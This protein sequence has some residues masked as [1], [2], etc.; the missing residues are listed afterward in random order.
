MYQIERASVSHIPWIVAVPKF[1]H[2]FASSSQIRDER[3]WKRLE[4]RRS[5]HQSGHSWVEGMYWVS[6]KADF[7]SR[8]S[9]ELHHWATRS[10]SEWPT[11]PHWGCFEKSP[12]C[13]G[14][15]WDISHGSP[16]FAAYN[17]MEWW[18]C[19]SEWRQEMEI[20]SRSSVRTISLYETTTLQGIVV[21]ESVVQTSGSRET[22]ECLRTRMP[23]MR[24]K[25]WPG[26]SRAIYL[27]SSSGRDHKTCLFSFEA[28]LKPSSPDGKATIKPTWV[29]LS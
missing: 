3:Y 2:L 19:G 26:R 1:K 17:V 23:S 28:G 22:K 25:G 27:S 14:L 24:E 10:L 4:L 20:L 5:Y 13:T 16:V 6:D 18:H 15:L 12:H 7:Q 21:L 11:S 9:Q 8:V 29:P